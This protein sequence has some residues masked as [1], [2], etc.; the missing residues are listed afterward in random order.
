M[1]TDELLSQIV[2]HLRVI[3]DAS[4]LP[5]L[6]ATHAEW[7]TKTFERLDSLLVNGAPLPSRWQPPHTLPTPAVQRVRDLASAVDDVQREL[8]A[9]TTLVEEVQRELNVHPTWNPGDHS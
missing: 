6:R 9:V 2:R 7:L 5:P 3:N 8:S 4:T 1:S